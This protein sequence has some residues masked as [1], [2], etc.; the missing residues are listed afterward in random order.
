MKKIIILSFCISS[1]GAN[2]QAVKLT[3]GKKITTVRTSKVEMDMGEGG[4]MTIENN[5]TAVIT[6]KS[7]EG[8]NYKA[9][10]ATTKLK[11]SQE[12]AGISE[13]FDSENKG[14][15]S[16]MAMAIMQSLNVPEG[17]LINKTTGV[18]TDAS[19]EKSET[20]D[21][22][23]FGAFMGNKSTAEEAAVVFF[24]IPAGKKVGDKWAD[25]SNINGMK[26]V[27]HYELQS[28]NQNEA[29]VK[30][31]TN[32]KGMSSKDAD[33]T[34]VMITLNGTLESIFTTDPS[35][36]IVKKITTTGNVDGS[37]DAGGESVQLTMTI[38]N[39]QVNN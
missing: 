15:T 30:V 4:Q 12:G 31:T 9:E 21:E 32:T 10:T 28:L 8:D 7:A 27:R 23:P 16:Q 24:V 1:L 25:S 38:N 17:I 20:E 29:V 5:R 2:A 22:N 19:P 33:G 6:I 11:T 39:S 3:A 14:D 18:V 34:Q 13:S 36:G 37:M 35:A 26:N